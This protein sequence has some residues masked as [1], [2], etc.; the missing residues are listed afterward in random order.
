MSSYMYINYYRPKRSFGQ[1]NVF[2]RVCDS[3]N[4]GGCL[5]GGG[6]PPNLGGSAWGGSLQIFFLGG[7]LQIF[8]GGLPGGGFPPNFGGGSAWGG[9]LQ[10]FMGGLPGGGDSSKFLWGGFSPG[11]QSTFGRYASYW[12]AFLLNY[13]NLTNKILRFNDI[14]TL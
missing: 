7:F 6:V 13:Y 14:F 5:P 4:R 3:V 11:I 12:N 10:I 9:F 2:T 1:G 8:G